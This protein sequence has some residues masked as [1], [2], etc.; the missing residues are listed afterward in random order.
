MLASLITSWQIDG[1][2]METVTDFIFMG[3]KITADD[4]CSHEIK[5]CLLLGRKVMTN[6][7]SILKKQRHYF[8]NKCPSSQSYG[9]SSS[10]VWMWALDYKESGALKNSCF[11]TVV[12]EQTLESTLDCKKIQSAHPKGNQSRILIERTDVEA[13]TPVLWPPDAKNWPTWKDADAG[14]DWRWEEKG[15]TEDEIVGWHHRHNGHEFQ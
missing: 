4:D 9:F 5:R 7:D 6:L 15:M 3:S 2:I 8:V 13:E 1:E 11:W 10:H 14:K 12:F